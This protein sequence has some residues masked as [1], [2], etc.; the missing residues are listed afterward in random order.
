MAYIL[1]KIPPPPRS[2]APGIQPDPAGAGFGLPL[3]LAGDHRRLAALGL[4]TR[5]SEPEPLVFAQSPLAAPLCFAGSP[6]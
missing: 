5:V 1:S 2:V 4:L 3:A 6:G